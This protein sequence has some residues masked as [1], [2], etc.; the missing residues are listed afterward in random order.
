MDTRGSHAG[1]CKC[2]KQANKEEGPIERH[3]TLVFHFCKAAGYSTALESLGLVNG[4]ARPADVL[5]SGL[6][7][8]HPKTALDVTITSSLQKNYINYAAKQTGYNMDKAFKA[9]MDRFP[10]LTEKGIRLV[11]LVWETTGG[12]S[13]SVHTLFQDLA[14]ME[15][16]RTVSEPKRFCSLF[17]QRS[18]AVCKDLC[19][20]LLFRGVPSW[21][22]DT[23]YNCDQ[24]DLKFLCCGKLC[25][26]YFHPSARICLIK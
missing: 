19:L 25:V 18:R 14:M 17:T 9:K 7:R 21:K 5:V 3:N 15:A 11:P 20:A 23:R 8:S 12:A 10:E 1:C 26:F 2:G 16:K 22:V 6:H 13:D 24:T 4:Q